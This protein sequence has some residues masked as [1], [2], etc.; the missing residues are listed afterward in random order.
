MSSSKDNLQFIRQWYEV[1]PEFKT[2]SLYVSGESY[3]GIYVPYMSWQIYTFNQKQKS[4]DKINL[5]G[6][7]VGNGCTNWEYDSLPAMLSTLYYRNVMDTETWDMFNK[8]KCLDK[9]YMTK[10]PVSCW[11]IYR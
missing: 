8:E 9:N 4:A 10:W 5:K 7:L 3:G 11:G 2:N 1:Y 6:M